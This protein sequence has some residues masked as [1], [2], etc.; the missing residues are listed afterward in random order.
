VYASVHRN[1]SPALKLLLCQTVIK[2]CVGNYYLVEE[3]TRTRRGL[4]FFLP[5]WVSELETASRRVRLRRTKMQLRFSQYCFTAH[6]AAS[7]SVYDNTDW[8][9]AKSF[10]S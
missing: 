5:R 4:S 1:V 10:E 9:D 8:C 7:D 6:K 2:H 3:R